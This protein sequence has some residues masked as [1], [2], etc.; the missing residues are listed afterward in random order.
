[1]VISHRCKCGRI[2]HGLAEALKQSDQDTGR[3]IQA[4]T[5][6]RMVLK[7]NDSGWYDGMTAW[8]DILAKA[9]EILGKP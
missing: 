7:A 1:M 2:C 8:P 6:A 5:L 9:R 4:I 3:T